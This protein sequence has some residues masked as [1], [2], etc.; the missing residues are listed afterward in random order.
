MGPR[1]PPERLANGQDIVKIYKEQAVFPHV[2][3]S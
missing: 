3:L 2:T 1:P